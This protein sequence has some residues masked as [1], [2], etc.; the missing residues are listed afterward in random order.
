MIP[1]LSKI[2]RVTYI[3]HI[4]KHSPPVS[5]FE[6]I[7]P[8]SSPPINILLSVKITNTTTEQT[9]NTKTVKPS[10]PAGTL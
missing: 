1:T 7:G 4:K 10:L 9:K 8:P 5:T 2:D 3:P 6:A